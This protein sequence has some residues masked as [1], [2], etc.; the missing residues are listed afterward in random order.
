ME[1]NSN[2]GIISVIIETAT[3]GGTIGA[4]AAEVTGASIAAGTLK[5]M[6]VGGGIGAIVDILEECVDSYA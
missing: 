6:V 2:M 1:G 5:G 4:L 3:F